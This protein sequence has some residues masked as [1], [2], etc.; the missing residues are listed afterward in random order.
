[1]VHDPFDVLLNQLANILLRNFA[2]IFIRDIGLYLSFFVTS[3]SGFG[4]TVL[5][6]S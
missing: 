3:L 2:S 1:M 5:V 6:A 4:I